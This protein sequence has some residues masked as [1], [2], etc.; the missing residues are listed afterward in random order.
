MNF[1]NIPQPRGSQMIVEI[2]EHNGT[3]KGIVLPDHRILDFRI[4][5]VRAIGPEVNSS[6]SNDGRY[7]EKPKEF[8]LSVG[9]RVILNTYQGVPLNVGGKAMTMLN[10]DG[11][12]AIVSE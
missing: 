7:V 5:L 4:G 11:A 9:D 6:R 8:R 12:F 10:A 3:D 1:K 2:V